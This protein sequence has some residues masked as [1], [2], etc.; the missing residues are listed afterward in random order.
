MFEVH[1]HSLIVDLFSFKSGGQTE[2]FIILCNP[3]IVSAAS[4]Q[5]CR[6]FGKLKFLNC[7]DKQG[8][9]HKTK[10]K[11]LYFKLSKNGHSKKTSLQKYRS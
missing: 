10:G 1:F 8:V 11:N 7:Q 4:K 9:R 6:C 5:K 2:M 3:V